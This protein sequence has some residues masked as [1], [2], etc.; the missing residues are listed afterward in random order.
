MSRTLLRRS[1]A[2]G[3]LV[4]V[5]LGGAAGV[6]AL[7]GSDHQDTPEVELSPRMD[8]NDVYAFPGASDSRIVLVMTTSSPITP[9]QAASAAFDP[10]LLYQ[11]KIDNDNDAVEDYVLQFTF[12]GSAP[13]QTVRMRGPM[14]PAMTGTLS[15]LANVSPT[16]SGAINATLGDA[17]GIQLFAGIRDDPFF[18]DL[19]QFFCI[20]PDRKPATG[21]LAEPCATGVSGGFRAS[22]QAVDYLSGYNT[23]AIVVELPETM[24]TAGGTSKLGVWA[25]ISR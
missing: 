5:A 3:A 13:N 15:K 24:L 6:T 17:A 21:P 25:T 11:L 16:L 18:L 1:A 19:E 22:G 23:L 9:A 2:A 14:A 7:V 20:I 4:L 10:D 12:E 8:I